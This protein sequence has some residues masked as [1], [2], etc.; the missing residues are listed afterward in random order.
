M[1]SRLGAGG[2]H[3]AGGEDRLFHA[4]TLLLRISERPPE[5]HRPPIALVSL[6]VDLGASECSQSSFGLGDELPSRG[7]LVSLIHPPQAVEPVGHRFV[8]QASSR[9]RSPN[10]G[11]ASGSKQPYPLRG[12]LGTLWRNT[13]RSS[14][15][16]DQ[17]PWIVGS[18]SI[19]SATVIPEATT[20]PSTVKP[21]STVAR[22]LL[23]WRLMKNSIVAL[24][25]A[26]P[27]HTIQMVPA[28]LDEPGSLTTAGSLTM[29]ENVSV[30]EW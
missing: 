18:A 23:S 19:S 21:S 2:T 29:L 11:T 6:Q 20:S 10:S 9:A 1:T 8:D 30:A 25:T 27:S 28:M 13:S 5:F 12:S 14:L 24:L 15:L 4:D 22:K 17:R 7:Q 16:S 3:R 26:P